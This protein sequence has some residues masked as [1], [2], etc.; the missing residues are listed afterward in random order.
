MR[1]D[2]GRRV[3]FG[4]RKN[5]RFQ[6]FSASGRFLEEWQRVGS[7]RGRALS[8]DGACHLADACNNRRFWVTCRVTSQLERRGSRST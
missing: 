6:V 8:P 7:A 4:G 1:V 3:L 5:N 2:P